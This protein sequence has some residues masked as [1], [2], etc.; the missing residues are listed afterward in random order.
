MEQQSRKGMHASGELQSLMRQVEDCRAEHQHHSRRSQSL[1]AAHA[2]LKSLHSQAVVRE[3][4]AGGG[5]AGGGSGMMRAI[6]MMKVR[7]HQERERV[8]IRRLQKQRHAAFTADQARLARSGEQGVKQELE[9]RGGWSTEGNTGPEDQD[10]QQ[11]LSHPLLTGWNDAKSR[12]VSMASTVGGLALGKK[13]ELY[14]AVTG[15]QEQATEVIHGPEDGPPENWSDLTPDRGE[16]EGHLG[17]LTS[18][19]GGLEGAMSAMEGLGEQA[20]TILGP[21]GN[22]KGVY[23]KGK[24]ARTSHKAA[25]AAGGIKHKHSDDSARWYR[26]RSRAREVLELRRGKNATGDK[27]RTNRGLMWSLKMGF[28]GHLEDSRRRVLDRQG[29]RHSQVPELRDLVA[30][31]TGGHAVIGDLARNLESAHIRERGRKAAGALKH[32]IDL[33][34]DPLAVATGGASEAV[35]KPL[36]LALGAGDLAVPVFGKI[37][38]DRGNAKAQST[39][40]T[41]GSQAAR[42]SA[43][44]H[45]L[46]HDYQ[47]ARR[48]VEAIGTGV[49][50]QGPSHSIASDLASTDSTKHGEALARIQEGESSTFSLSDQVRASAGLPGMAKRVGAAER[51]RIALKKNHGEDVTRLVEMYGSDDLKADTNENALGLS[52]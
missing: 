33:A 40:E 27:G 43:A 30:P 23:K 39:L 49:D 22:L 45:I 7:A 10:R 51:H 38:R 2:H 11:L 20:D 50:N 35:T 37:M 21:I 6:G 18:G 36:S 34:A 13:K 31:R 9:D 47:A 17:A 52:E 5:G 46:S 16:V 44:K 28:G 41:T 48:V 25:R 1:A 26:P 24:A 19:A 8:T 32:G 29:T 12:Q 4:A 14:D 15:V 42:A 3:T